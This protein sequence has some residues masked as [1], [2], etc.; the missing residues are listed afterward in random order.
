MSLLVAS[1]NVFVNVEKDSIVQAMENIGFHVTTESII[2][3]T[4]KYDDDIVNYV[5]IKG[6]KL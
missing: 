2:V 6:V 4:D 1:S 5:E 3:T